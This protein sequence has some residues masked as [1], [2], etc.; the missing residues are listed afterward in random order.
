MDILK[1]EDNDIILNTY[2]NG[3]QMGGLSLFGLDK[4]W[5]NKK[6]VI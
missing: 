6:W 5:L 1:I 2:K 3:W 4:K